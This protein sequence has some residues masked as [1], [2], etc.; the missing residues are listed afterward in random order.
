VVMD[1]K[2][3]GLELGCGM[4]RAQRDEAWAQNG[5]GGGRGSLWALFTGEAVR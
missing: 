2:G 4:S 5:T 3:G 1:Q